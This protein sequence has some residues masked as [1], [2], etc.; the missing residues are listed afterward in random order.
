MTEQPRKREKQERDR[1]KKKQTK[2]IPINNLR[3]S[4]SKQYQTSELPLPHHQSEMDQNYFHCGA[5]AKIME[6][7]RKRT[8]SPETLRL[9]ERRL[10]IARPGTIRRRYDQIAQ[11][12]IWVPSRPDKRSR[13]EIAEIDGKFINWANRLGGGY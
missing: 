10:E 12:T 6:T 5:T 3:N 13:E 1:T 9:V 4:K 8:T 11:R 7:I 2:T